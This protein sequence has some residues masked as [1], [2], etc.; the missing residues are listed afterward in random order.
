MEKTIKGMTTCKVCGR[1]FPL[2]AE[3][4][5]VSKEPGRQGFAAVAGG[6]APVLWD[7][8]DCPHCGCQNRMQQRNRLTDLFGQDLPLDYDEE[9]E[10]EDDP[11]VCDFS[12]GGE[13][14]CKDTCGPDCEFH[15]DH[16][17]HPN[18]EEKE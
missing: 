6:P 17:P 15:P 8:F 4:H 16:N 5:Y 12:S 18:R 1:D 14:Y 11:P 7:S 13:C 2:I 10:D 9:D 3:E